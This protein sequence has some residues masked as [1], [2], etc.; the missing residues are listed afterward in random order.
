MYTYIYSKE[1]AIQGILHGKIC[2]IHHRLLEVTFETATAPELRQKHPLWVVVLVVV[3]VYRIGLP[4]SRR[5]QAL[6]TSPGHYP[7]GESHSEMTRCPT[8]CCIL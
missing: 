5:G 7:S 8:Q 3:V 4:N 2:S 1:L 6:E